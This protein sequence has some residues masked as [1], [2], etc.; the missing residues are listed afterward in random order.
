MTTD[1]SLPYKSLLSSSAKSQKKGHAFFPQTLHCPSRPTTHFQSHVVTQL[2]ASLISKRKEK[3]RK[4]KRELKIAICLSDRA[5]MSRGYE[6]MAVSNFKGLR[7]THETEGRREDWAVRLGD[8]A[9]FHLC[10]QDRLFTVAANE[11][12]LWPF[13]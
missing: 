6:V 2:A 7:Q 11:L 8:V 1:K 4:K 3:R 12:E 9:N 5:M 10:Q 13:G